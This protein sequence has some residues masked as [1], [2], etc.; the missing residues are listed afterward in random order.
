MWT[1]RKERP[2]V[3]MVLDEQVPAAQLSCAGCGGWL[4]PWGFARVRSIRERGGPRRQVRPRRVRCPDCRV[5]HV[6]LNAE[7]V[8]RRADALDTIGAALLA[9][10]AGHGH[11]TIATEL[12]VAPGTVRGWLRR[13]AAWAEW[14]RGAATGLALQADPLLGAAAPTGSA[15]GDALDALGA[16]VAALVRRVGPI[17]RPW[18]L[19]AIIARGRLLA[20]LRN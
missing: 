14:V 17:A 20:P 15:L 1:W 8:P 7:Y 6:L 5:T 9:K 19:A 3:I 16:A 10:A 18:P 11:R 12:G 4:R 13:A 2:V